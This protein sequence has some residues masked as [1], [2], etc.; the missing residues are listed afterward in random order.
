M[1]DLE[2]RNFSVANSDLG[3]SQRVQ[4]VVQ[5][6]AQFHRIEG[7]TDATLK[8]YDK[9][10]G[11]FVGY[12]VGQGKVL[13]V[14]LTS[15]DIMAYMGALKDGGLALRTRLQAI[16]M[17]FRWAKTWVLVDTNPAERLKPPWR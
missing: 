4:S 9:E 12:V 16:S 13:T 3:V 8:F 11:F 17:F 15:L 1:G 14:D 6:Y 10:P 2:A 5:A 7:S